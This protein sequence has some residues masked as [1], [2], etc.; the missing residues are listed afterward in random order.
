[1]YVFLTNCVNTEYRTVT[2]NISRKYPRSTLSCHCNVTLEYILS[3]ES[4][5]MFRNLTIKIKKNI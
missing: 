5:K 3:R 4:K 2:E 1:M